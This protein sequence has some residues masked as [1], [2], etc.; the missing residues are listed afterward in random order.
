MV[1]IDEQHRFGVAQ[2]ALLRDKGGLLHAGERAAPHLLVMTATPIPRTLALTVYGDLDVTM[3]DELPPG[4]EPPATQGAARQD[5]RAP[6][7]SRRCAPRSTTGGRPIGSARSSRSRRSS[8]SRH[9]AR[10]RHRGG[11]LAARRA[12]RR[13]DR[14]GARPAADRRARSGDARLSR[15]RAA[16][17]GGH[18]GDR[19]RRRRAGGVDDDHRGRRA[20]RPGAAAPAARAHRPRRRAL[21]AACLL[22]GSRAGDAGDRLAVMAETTDGFKVA[23]D[24]LRI[25]GPG[26]LFGT[27]QAG[28]PRLRYADLVRDVEL[29]RAGARP[30]RSRCSS[31]I[32]RWRRPSTR[33][34]ARCSTPAGPRRACSARKPADAAGAC[35]ASLRAHPTHLRSSGGAA[36]CESSRCVS[37]W[38]CWSSASRA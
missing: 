19:G 7:R 4:R 17:A 27:R 25:R 22:A 28:L 26:E 23:E 24:D 18:H 29:L 9:Q 10:R 31:A 6:A 38:R 30:R 14:P 1:V 16:R 20:L 34:R 21:D 36:W 2:R 15:R 37:R 11:R 3:L 32:R 12:R 13:A 8:S 5:R 35:D 33:P